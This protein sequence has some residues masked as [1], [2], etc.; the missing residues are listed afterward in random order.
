MK[1]KVKKIFILCIPLLVGILSSFFVDKHFYQ[2][3]HLPNFAPPTLLFPIVWTILYL[4]MGVVLLR[5][6]KSNN[7]EELILFGGQLFFNF[8]WVLLFF[9]TKLFLLSFLLLVLLDICVLYLLL[10][11]KKIDSFSFYLMIPYM[12]WLYFAS[13]LN[14]SIFLLN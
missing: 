10:Q 3:I 13:Y 5:L 9:Q 14:W 12:L 2:S 1:E 6:W 8:V 4:L 11:L 7:K